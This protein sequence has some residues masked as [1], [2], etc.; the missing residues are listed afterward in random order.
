MI[1]KK[2]LL[3]IVSITALGLLGILNV[4]EASAAPEMKRLEGFDS[5]KQYNDLQ[6]IEHTFV[7]ALKYK[8]KR[9]DISEKSLL[10][11]VYPSKTDTQLQTA[12][13]SIK[14]CISYA[15]SLGVQMN[16][17][18][19]NSEGIDFQILKKEI[20]KGNPSILCFKPK[21]P[22]WREPYLLAL[23]HGYIFV[24]ADGVSLK[25]PF[26]SLSIWTSNY[27]YPTTINVKEKTNSI[28]MTDF[29]TNNNPEREYL[30]YGYILF[31]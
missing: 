29:S 24:E 6:G 10:K 7:E 17:V 8:T 3:F 31:N 9:S 12:S 21:V 13:A 19:A 4:T 27:I 20:D 25:D 18:D 14:D 15:T 26:Q 22:D 30:H 28:T 23:V 5:S 1:K 11:Y 16:W 2:I